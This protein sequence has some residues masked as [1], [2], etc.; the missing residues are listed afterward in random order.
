[1][2]TY[3]YKNSSAAKL[4]VVDDFRPG[5]WVSIES[6]TQPELKQLASRFKLDI[7]R[8]ADVLD[9]DEIPRLE[10]D[11]GATYLY[12]RYTLE[13]DM[14]GPITAPLLCVVKQNMLLTISYGKLTVLQNFTTEKVQFATTQPVELMLSVIDQVIDRYEV[15]INNMTKRIKIFRTK[16]TNRDIDNKDFVEFVVVEDGLNSFMSA[17]QPATAIMSRLLLGR[18]IEVTVSRRTQMKDLLLN[19]QQLIE[20]CQSS[21]K[22][23][24]TIRN[25][26]TT[27]ASNNLN[28]TMKILTVATLLI[29]I[30]N[31]FFGMYGMNV[32]LPFQQ[33]IW[34]YT[35]IIGMTLF[36]TLVVIIFARSRK[37]F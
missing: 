17:L 11:D 2:I 31:A 3:Y 34:A 26:Y 22:S 23:I 10:Y 12:L 25:V 19:T 35:F 33:E 13:E 9:V 15:H 30:P 20:E 24:T 8:M 28:R 4:T 6:P 27:I 21:I 36:V 14:T 32:K 18:H 37:I 29:A 5:A 16:F 1:M 7:N